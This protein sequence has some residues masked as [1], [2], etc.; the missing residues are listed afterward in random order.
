MTYSAPVVSSTTSYTV[1]VTVTASFPTGE[2]LT[3][4]VSFTVN[5][6]PILSFTNAATS[7]TLSVKGA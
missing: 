3:Q 1:T 6:D 5:V 2:V 4:D 7:G